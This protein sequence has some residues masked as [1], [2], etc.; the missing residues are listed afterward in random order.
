M[1]K[2]LIISIVAIVLAVA[3]SV[4]LFFVFGK[5]NNDDKAK[6]AEQYIALEGRAL[7]DLVN[8]LLAE[9]TDSGSTDLVDPLKSASSAIIDIIPS[10]DLLAMIGAEDFGWI[11][12]FTMTMDVLQDGSMIQTIMGIGLNGKTIASLDMI[13]DP[14]SGISYLAIPTISQYYLKAQNAATPNMAPAMDSVMELLNALPTMRDSVNTYVDL[15]LAEMK[16][17]EKG[18]ENITVGD[19]SEKVTVYTNYITDKVAYDIITSV[20]NQAKSDSALKDLLPE[21]VDLEAEIDNILATLPKDA[22][23]NKDE[24]IVLK[25]YLDDEDN[26]IGRK[27][28]ILGQAQFYYHGI[29]GGDAMEIGFIAEGSG[30]IFEADLS[31]SSNSFILYLVEDGEP[32]ELGAL[33]ITGDETK[34]SC[35]LKLSEDAAAML[36][37][38][39]SASINAA[40]K[41]NWETANDQTVITMLLSMMGEDMEVASLTFTGDDTTG[42]CELKLSDAIESLIFQSTEVDPA[43]LISWGNDDDT[44]AKMVLSLA[45]TSLVTFEM[46]A[47][48][49]TPTDIEIPSDSLDLA[50]PNAMQAFVNSLNLNTL[51][52]NMLDANIPAQLVNE[53]I[54]NLDS[55]VAQSKQ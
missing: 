15:V 52:Q 11:N 21:G 16:H 33:I 18:T 35:E 19:S 47:T 23:D 34:G 3:I 29:D 50:D 20:L 36:F 54:S 28:D 1:S 5:K 45:G 8:V 32:V 31:G 41:F 51:R 27:F 49:K 9:N 7:H 44:D 37:G 24:A 14:L 30:V 4:S 13:N 38:S 39:S 2:K 46:T 48:E 6:L 55:L 12:K 22:E 53:L 17:I 10:D 43:I 26:V 42:T 40:L 25:V